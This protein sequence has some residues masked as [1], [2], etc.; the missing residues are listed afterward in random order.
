M[1][2]TFV[3]R[4]REHLKE[5]MNRYSSDPM[6]QRLITAYTIAIKTHYMGI[7]DWRDFLLHC[8]YNPG[9]EL[10][11]LLSNC[12]D[13]VEKDLEAIKHEEFDL[14]NIPEE[15]DANLD[16]KNDYDKKYYQENKAKKLKYQKEYYQNNREERKAYQREYYKRSKEETN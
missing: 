1:N 2:K 11:I 9:A 8:Y 6:Q 10:E 16:A 13:E 14:E 12:K 15:L 7:E 4:Y 5:N 3:K